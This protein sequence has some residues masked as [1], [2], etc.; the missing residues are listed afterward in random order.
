MNVLIVASLRCKVPLTLEELKEY[1]KFLTEDDIAALEALG[2]DLGSRI[3]RGE[4][5]GKA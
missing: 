5:R 3:V 4:L 1:E 2:P